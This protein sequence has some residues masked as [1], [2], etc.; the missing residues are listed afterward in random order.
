MTSPRCNQERGAVEKQS[1][2]RHAT[3]NFSPHHAGEAIRNPADAVHVECPVSHS[4]RPLTRLLPALIAL[5]AA[6]ATHAAAPDAITYLPYIQPGDAS[7]LGEHDQV[8]VAFQT[9]TASG[10][11]APATYVVEFGAVEADD[12]VRYSQRV[13]ASGRVVNHYLASAGI[14]TPATASGARIDYTALVQGLAHDRTYQYRVIGPGLPAA[15]FTAR[16]HTRPTGGR[17]SFQVM[18]D[19]GFFPATGSK[20]ATGDALSAD[21]EARIANTMF[22]VTSLQVSGA[23]KLSAPALA[24]NTGDNVYTTGSEGT[25]RDY[26]FP[27]WNSDVASN[28]RGAPYVRSIPYYIVVG[29][30]DIGATGVSA[31]LLGGGTTGRFSGQTDGGDALAY[32][33]NYY[34]PLN[35]PLGVD[36]QYTCVVDACTPNAWYFGFDAAKNPVSNAAGV[37]AFRATTLVDTGK[38]PKEQAARMSNYSFDAG[39]VHFVFLD[40]NPHLFSGNLPSTSPA[41]APQQGFTAYPTALANWLVNDLDQTRQTWKVVVFHQPAFS[42]GNATLF[43]DQMRQTVTFLQDH[44]VNM[45]F[46]GHEHNYQR[47]QPLRALQP[48]TGAPAAPGSATPLV[49]VDSE[50]DGHSHTAADGVLYLVEGAGG[51]RDFDNNETGGRGS[52]GLDQDDAATG[53]TAV[54]LGSGTTAKSVSLANG[55]ASWLDTRLTNTEMQAFDPAAGEGAT[56]ITTRFKAKLFSF[57]HV[58]VNGDE[59]ALYQISEPLSATASTAFGTDWQGQFVNAPLADTTIDQTLALALPGTALP[60]TV[61]A[62]GSGQPALLDKFVVTRPDVSGQ[63]KVSAGM[64]QRSGNGLVSWTLQAVNMGPQPLS[65]AQFVATLPKGCTLADP[66]STSETLHGRTVVLSLGHLGGKGSSD[67]HVSATLRCLSEGDDE[68]GVL[69][70]SLRSATARTVEAAGLDN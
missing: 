16:F 10:S 56:K 62:A 26:W 37:S 19:E 3:V 68:V 15:G 27:V 43:N 70:L 1:S 40:A 67:D 13:I 28:D 55:P 32:F 54:T 17:F 25:Y 24:L 41:S 45:V 30:H 51:N 59:L 47:T 18:G 58:E 49:A 7:S 57:A 23:P 61:Q 52:A 31:D 34:F 66:L 21:Y 12:S 4:V 38:G 60:A 20:T 29:N 36:P 39:N 64:P 48:L 6:S 69:R 46:N 5:L 14:A 50:W 63:V 8:V 2:M 53:T 65:G 35:G 42:S 11:L 44:G 33:N 9:D 22:N